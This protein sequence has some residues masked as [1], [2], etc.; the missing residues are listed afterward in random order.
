MNF[1]TGITKCK[2]VQM[3]SFIYVQKMNEVV[4]IPATGYFFCALPLQGVSIANDNNG[5]ASDTH[6]CRVIFPVTCLL[7]WLNQTAQPAWPC[8][9]LFPFVLPLQRVIMFVIPD[10]FWDV[11]NRLLMK[12]R[13]LIFYAVI[14]RNYC[15]SKSDVW[16]TV[17][18]NLVWIRKGN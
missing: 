7:L 3:F 12:H 2:T 10:C 5:D 8:P 4:S 15:I 18:R 1:L 14:N 16:L 9:Q 11:R 6:S 13:P 17:H